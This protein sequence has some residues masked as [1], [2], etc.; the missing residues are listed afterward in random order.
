MNSIL[1]LISVLV[2]L[3]GCTS[4]QD[5]R[6]QR[7]CSVWKDQGALG[8]YEVKVNQ[9]RVTANT[10]CLLMFWWCSSF[11]SHIDNEGLIF[12]KGSWGSERQVATLKDNQV[13]YE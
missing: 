12:A 3:N 1:I 4:T 9:R 2:L 7:S 13:V 8:P 10:K 5:L 6:A 11:E